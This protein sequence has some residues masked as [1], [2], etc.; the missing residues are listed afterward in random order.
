QFGYESAVAPFDLCVEA[1]ALG[2]GVDFQTD[3]TGFLA[4]VVSQPIEVGQLGPNAPQLLALATAGRV[5]LVAEAL[6]QLRAGVGRHVAIGAW[7]PGPFTL[8]WQLFG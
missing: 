6:R 3:G 5:P 2:A 8:S 4:P 7:I 1:E